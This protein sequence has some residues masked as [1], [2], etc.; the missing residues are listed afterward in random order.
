MT[1]AIV[2]QS[3]ESRTE[4]VE[5]VSLFKVQ[6]RIFFV[7]Y[8]DEEKDVF[9]VSD[10]RTGFHV[11]IADDSEHGAIERAKFYLSCLKNMQMRYREYEDECGIFE[12]NEDIV[13]AENLV[14]KDGF[15]ICP[16]AME[17]FDD[18]SICRYKNIEA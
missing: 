7:H 15:L 10:L 3:K 12:S 5:V 1:L 18:P 2:S 9:G 16:C 4:I 11:V 8:W 14:E 6:N 13:K 17:C